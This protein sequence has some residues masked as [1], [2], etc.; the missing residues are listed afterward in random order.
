MVLSFLG[1]A[2]LPLYIRHVGKL[3]S[4]DLL[5]HEV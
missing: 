1:Q 4:K 3:S 5:A 2:D